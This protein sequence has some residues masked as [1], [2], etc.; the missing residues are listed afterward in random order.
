MTADTPLAP[1]LRFPE[2]HDAP[3][4]PR[5]LM[6]RYLSESRIK[7]SGGHEAKKLTVKLWGKGVFKKNESVQGSANTQYYR[8]RAGQFIYSKLDFLNQAFGIIPV[9]LDGFES[10]VDLP[11]FDIASEMKPKFLLEYVQREQFYKTRG[12]IADGGRKAKRIQV[13]TFLDCPIYTPSEQEQ[14]KIAAC[15]GSLDDVIA[16]QGRKLE[17]LRHHKQGLMQQLFPRPGEAVP[18]LRFPEFRN[19]PGWQPTTIGKHVE[20]ISGFP[21]AGADIVEDKSGTRLL[22]GINITE[23]VIRHNVEIDRYYCG[24]TMGLEKYVLKKG[25]LVIGMDGSKVGKN[26]SLITPSDTGALLVQR[27]ARLRAKNYTTIRFIFY[28]VHSPK[29][30]AYVDRINTSSGIP[31][32]S[33]KQINEFAFCLPTEPEQ[34]RIADCLGLLDGLIAAQGRKLD[35][36]KQHKQGLMQ[37]LFPSPVS[38]GRR[39]DIHEPQRPRHASAAG[40]GKQA[41]LREDPPRVHQ[42]ASLQP[43]PVPE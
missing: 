27:V 16:A 23:G 9:H 26:S 35:T 19:E 13:A 43:R 37:R 1:K 33:A 12:E 4:W 25:D 42:T 22:R 28:H 29:F 3:G 14:Q 15:L 17:A 41:V 18:R 7:G 36:L 5:R 10:T 31:H 39:F 2:F 38:H 20:L 32:I 34:Y 8:R 6:S 21:F 11:C 40:T 30:H 24:S